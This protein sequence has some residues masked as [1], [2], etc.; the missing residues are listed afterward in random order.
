M[1]AAEPPADLRQI[2]VQREADLMV[3]VRVLKQ[4]H[5]SA[6]LHDIL[7]AVKPLPCKPARN[8]NTCSAKRGRRFTCLAC[9][10]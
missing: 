5:R 6:G 7:D 9:F 4:Q 8:V 1:N 2:M 10:V 3:A